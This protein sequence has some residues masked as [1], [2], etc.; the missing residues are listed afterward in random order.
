MSKLKSCSIILCLIIS[1]II[2]EVIRAKISIPI[3]IGDLLFLP[4]A[5][6]SSYVIM[7]YEFFNK[8]SLAEYNLAGP[9]SSLKKFGLLIASIL[10]LL[11]GVVGI[12]I[13]L[14]EPFVYR[15]GARGGCHGYTLAVIGLFLSIAGTFGI[16]KSIFIKFFSKKDSI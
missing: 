15:H 1:A 10:F 2:L 11:F 3:S 14:Q 6:L 5:L 9:V 13:G 12:W 8:K 4:I 16:W 7:R